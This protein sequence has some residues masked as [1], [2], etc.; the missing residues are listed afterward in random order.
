VNPQANA[1][2]A[3]PSLVLGILG[4]TICALC[5]PFAIWQGNQAKHA[6][7]NSGG[8]YGGGGMATAGQ[9]LGWVGTVLLVIGIIGGII[10]VAVGGD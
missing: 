6:I 4:V 1:P 8:Q 3:V 2:G 5:A 7:A 10:L 9:I